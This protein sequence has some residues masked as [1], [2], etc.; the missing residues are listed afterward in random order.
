MIATL[1][2]RIAAA[3]TVV[4][5][6][7]AGPAASVTPTCAARSTSTPTSAPTL[8]CSSLCQNL[9]KPSVTQSEA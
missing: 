8:R 6:V 9:D 1:V 2:K 7:G 4:A 3:G 5:L